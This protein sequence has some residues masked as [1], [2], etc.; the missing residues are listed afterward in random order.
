MG[1]ILLVSFKIGDRSI[2]EDAPIFFIAEAGVNHAGS[3][4]EAKEMVDVAKKCKADAV[5]FQ[6]IAWDEINSLKVECNHNFEWDSWRLTDEQMVQLFKQ[7]HDNGLAVTACVVDSAALKFI[8]EAGADFIK[9]VS[10][11]IT[12]HP[13]LKECASTGLPI[14]LSTGNALLSEIESA[15]DVIEKAGGRKVV[16]YQTNSQYPTPPDKVDLLALAILKDYKYPVGFCDHTKGSAISL[17]AVAIGAQIIEKHFSL[18][19]T[20][21]RPDYEVSMSPHEL[22]QL[23]SDI[24]IIEKAL[25]EP[26]KR[27]Y[28]DGS[29]SHM[30]VRRSI[31]ARHDL[32]RGSLIQWN[33]LA[34]KRPGTGMIPSKAESLIGSILKCGVKKGELLFENMIEAKPIITIVVICRLKS[35]RLPKKAL[36]PINGI[37]SVERCLLNC[38]AVPYVDQVVLATSCLPEDD[39]LEQFTIDGRVKVLRGDPDNVAER[40]VQGAQETGANIV[41]R[42]TGDCPVVSPEIL[43][44]LIEAHLKNGGDIT[45][46]TDDHA[47]G[48]SA[49]VY[50]VESLYR[51]VKQKK[52]LTHTEYLSFYYINN[53]E[54]FTVNRV[55]L[56]DEFRYPQWRLTLDEK[57]DLELF[58]NIYSNLDV[59]REPLFFLTLR[60]YLLNNPQ[61][62]Q[63]NSDV[64][65]K[66]KDDKR[67]IDEISKATD[68]G[69]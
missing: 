16:L 29:N 42:V 68:L 32:L 67:L 27:R 64:L 58:E 6:H 20:K 14:F 2:G 38:L 23:I 61:I 10:G 4:I 69:Y 9:I 45:L 40:M 54:I 65:L 17:A 50:T 36:L 28:L 18:D 52:P 31:T 37:A 55:R 30:L 13:F 12:C 57:K 41:L 1:G 44:I 62:T 53:P 59:K 25:G 3:F 39:P 15:L 22:C 56:P 35:T 7:A 5:T 8:V 34:Y 48:T 66:W 60:D 24:R 19:P 46:S 21:I 63:I 43:K 47:P 11:D 51:L 33:D 26:I 49:D